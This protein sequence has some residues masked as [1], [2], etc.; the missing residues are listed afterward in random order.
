MASRDPKAAGA[1]PRVLGRYLILDEIGSGGMA[2]VHLALHVGPLGFKRTV[3]IKRLHP[4]LAKDAE[5]VAMFVDE[6]RLAARVQH[7]SVVA[8]ID[9]VAAPNEL[10]LVM[11]YV[12]GETLSR[13]WRASLDRLERTP[14][15]VASA[16]VRDA[17]YGLHAAH[18]ARDEQNRP[19][20]IVHRDVSPQNLLVGVDG[21]AR[22]VDF[23][24]AKASVRST[25]TRD[26]Q[27]KGK[28]AYMAPEQL[29]GRPVD[30][31]A[32][33]FAASIVLWELLTGERLFRFDDV[34]EAV[35]SILHE[36]PRPPSSTCG[37]LPPGLDEVVLRGLARDPADRYAT[38]R[39]MAAALEGVC[40]PARAV[41]VGRWV[42]S[43]AG[44]A[45]AERLE[46]VAA[47][48]RLPTE[49]AE[50]EITAAGDQGSTLRSVL[51]ELAD[52]DDRAEAPT[53]TVV[54][55]ARTP[56]STSAVVA[57]EA[58]SSAAKTRG[59]PRWLVPLAATFVGAA[60]AV[61]LMRV[62][63]SDDGDPHQPATAAA[64][65]APPAAPPDEMTA[66]AAPAQ[67]DDNPPR[68][69]ET[70]SAPSGASS[71]P[72]TASARPAGAAAKRAPPA[73]ARGSPAASAPAAADCTPPYYFEDGI[74]RYKPACFGPR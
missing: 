1:L 24:V 29:R 22:M 21:V 63:R 16:I 66:A 70:P 60:A 51:R 32:D 42:E 59:A 33:V 25:V 11:E 13:L 35:H 9:V 34:G 15:A 57:A 52:R 55:A 14:P 30:R 73:A 2:S 74:K 45:L 65:E 17:L 28:L 41:D 54:P 4:Q 10:L 23:G 5:F 39:D 61:G 26:G 43:L 31:R 44:A 50:R 68:E 49:A 27:V 58:A 3:A 12:H 6:A 46:K 71:A 36:P 7:P 62:T 69:L 38:A 47:L 20:S 8:T 48:E 67:V 40:P 37:A 56:V 72:S 64:A 53:A 19:L 18:E